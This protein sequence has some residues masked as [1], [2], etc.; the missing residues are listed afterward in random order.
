MMELSCSS[1]EGVA[2]G[3][4]DSPTVRTPIPV[5]CGCEPELKQNETPPSHVDNGTD[6]TYD[7]VP[8]VSGEHWAQWPD[9]VKTLYTA[10]ER[11]ELAQL[12]HSSEHG[13]TFV[14][15]DEAVAADG[16]ALA[17]LQDSADDLDLDEKV[18]IVPWTSDDGDAF[19]DGTHLAFTHWSGT[20]SAGGIEWRQFC[21][22]VDADVLAGFVERHPFTDAHEPD[23]P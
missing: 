5:D 4:D 2:G 7:G 10:P 1:T 15:Y 20:P 9:I 18:A 16:N 11:P 19:P 3:G 6:L 14:W 12:V 8:P 13:W 23:G 21:A 17:Q 22:G